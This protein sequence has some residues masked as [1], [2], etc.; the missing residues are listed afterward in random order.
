MDG[1]K[2]IPENNSKKR[3]KISDDKNGKKNNDINNNAI[4][5]FMKILFNLWN[6]TINVKIK[7]LMYWWTL[8]LPTSPYFTMLN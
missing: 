8:A 4:N 3:E 2:S 1:K 5:I 6:G 7:I